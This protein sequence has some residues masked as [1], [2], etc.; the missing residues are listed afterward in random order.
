[1]DAQPE[2]FKKNG[3]HSS[4]VNGTNGHYV[5]SGV[6]DLLA[7]NGRPKS[8]TTLVDV[9]DSEP[10]IEWVESLGLFILRD[11]N[12]IA[13]MNRR[14][15]GRVVDILARMRKVRL[16]HIHLENH[17]LIVQFADPRTD[18]AE[19]ARILGEAVRLA[20]MPVP[21]GQMNSGMLSPRWS[22]FTSFS[23]ESGPVTS[24]LSVEVGRNRLRLQSESLVNSEATPAELA[25]LIPSL[26][27][28]RRRWLRHGITVKFDPGQTRP[29]DLIRAIDTICRLEAASLLP[30]TDENP[31]ASISLPRRMWHLG[32]AGASLVGAGVGLVVPGIPTVPFVLLT[33]YHLAKGSERMHRVFLQMPLFGSLAHD[34]SEGRF[35]RPANK[36]ILIALTTSIVGVT[37]LVTPVTPGI[38]MVVGLVFTMTTVSVLQTPSHA[39]AGLVPKVGISRGLRALPAMG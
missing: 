6:A 25:D 20:S 14:F 31:L 37:L 11:E 28:V 29:L 3:H 33:S 22:G 24:W 15:C 7:R 18:R 19:A 35:I 2:R 26:K 23:S 27:S 21:A 8:A 10:R 5:K 16:A 39:Q 13:R 36:V 32:L 12:V 17:E 30:E 9:P 4:R 38:L 1:M 34:W